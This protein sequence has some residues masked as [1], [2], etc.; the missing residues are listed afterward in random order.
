MPLSGVAASATMYAC[1]AAVGSTAPVKDR[2]PRLDAEGLR[3][4]AGRAEAELR[5]ACAVRVPSAEA[6]VDVAE[7]EA[8]CMNV[9]AAE[10]LQAIEAVFAEY[11][12]EYEAEAGYINCAHHING[13]AGGGAEEDGASSRVLFMDGGGEAA[14]VV[15]ADGPEVCGDWVSCKGEC[16]V[17]LDHMTSKLSYEEV[18]SD[19]GDR[20]HGFLEPV[21]A[22]AA[23]GSAAELLCWRADLVVLED[24]QM[25]WYGP[26][27]GEKPETVGDVQVLLRLGDSPRLETRIRVEGEDTDWQ[28]PVKFRRKQK[29][30]VP[31]DE[32]VFVFGGS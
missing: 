6:D 21:E 20:L 3:R 24:G 27:F 15:A 12:A 26:S 17:F 11:E 25:A 31:V 10:E 9:L 7:L 16:R 18:I 1:P 22:P 8:E 19:D 30:V 23:E 13:G 32:N 28:E 5:R 14:A 29:S 2:R 4:E